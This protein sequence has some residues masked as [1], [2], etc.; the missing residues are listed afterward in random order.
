MIK[1]RTRTI[2]ICTLAAL[3]LVGLVVAAYIQAPAAVISALVTSVGIFGAA[4]ADA[5]S[6][7][8]RR[9]DPTTSAIIDE[10]VETV[11]GLAKKPETSK[12]STS[13][14]SDAPPEHE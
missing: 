8:K 6:V 12:D 2:L 5:L 1:H 3:S 4:A 14:D 13:T 11:G 7:E 9:L 10:V